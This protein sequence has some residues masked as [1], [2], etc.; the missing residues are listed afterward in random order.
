M[1]V[2]GIEIV[3]PDPAQPR[4]R[5]QARVSSERHG[6]DECCWLEVPEALTDQLSCSGS[7]WLAAMLPVAATFGE[8]L[9]I[10]APVDPALLE[11]AREILRIWRGWDL[12]LRDV[13]LSAETE[14]VH[15]APA[16]PEDD[17][18]SG[19]FFSG[20][21]DSFFTVLHL[22][23]AAETLDE[24]VFIAGF[25]LQLNRA[26]AHRRIARELDAVSRGLGLSILRVATN[27]RQTRLGDTSWPLVAHGCAAAFVALAL[28]PRFRQMY[29][30]SSVNHDMETPWGSHPRTDPLLS[31][32]HLRLIHHEAETARFDKVRAIA[33]NP[34]VQ[35]HLRVCYRSQ[36]GAN[37]G[38]C[39][40][41]LTAMAMLDALGTLESASCFGGGALDLQRLRRLRVNA[42][43]DRW[44]LTV[45]R[46][47]AARTGR[48]AL[49]ETLTHVVDASDGSWHRI[50][51]HV[52]RRLSLL[53]PV[54]RDWLRRLHLRPFARR[55]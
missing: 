7:P 40:K 47:A 42:P 46:E 20:G 5:L 18:L 53:A 1:H 28:E 3:R 50:G 13:E 33:A 31:T 52:H 12:G 36:D 9:R 24:L 10:D 43:W 6:Q 29:F 23:E 45:I 15:P 4:V 14:A 27:L 16:Q 39:A 51:Y 32:R 25:D 34:L 38:R 44:Q 17:R 11:G 54:I 21:V 35:R 8:P 22:R 2:S 30:A 19:A 26:E 55:S 37:C 49:A 48:S 41:C